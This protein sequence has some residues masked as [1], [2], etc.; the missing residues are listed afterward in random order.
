MASDDDA[1]TIMT[2]DELSDVVGKVIE[3]TLEKHK[4]DQDAQTAKAVAD[5]LAE[6][7]KIKEPDNTDD[8]PNPNNKAITSATEMKAEEFVKRGPWPTDNLPLA[9]GMFFSDVRAACGPSGGRL[10]DYMRQWSNFL[11]K[12]EAKVWMNEGD[13]EQGGFLVPADVGAHIYADGLESSVVRPY[14][15]Q[16]YSLRGNR[17]NISADVDNTHATTFFG[18]LTVYWTQEH[19]AKT[20]TIGVLHIFQI[21]QYFFPLCNKD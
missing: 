4:E 7:N 14:S 12:P 1:K 3:A 19:G 16:L 8:E 2:V 6:A 5:A 11:R 21:H 18:G 9:T 20:G 10:S 15:P 17:V 13:D